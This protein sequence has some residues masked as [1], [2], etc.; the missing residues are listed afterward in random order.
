MTLHTGPQGI[1]GTNGTNG[2]NGAKGDTGPVGPSYF[3]QSGTNI[4]YSGGLVV[5]NEINIQN[6][7][8]TKSMQFA[9]VDNYSLGGGWFPASSSA[10]RIYHSAINAYSYINAYPLVI[11]DFSLTA[12]A[13]AAGNTEQQLY[14]PLPEYIYIDIHLNELTLILPNINSNVGGVDPKTQIFRFQIR[15][16]NQSQG[17]YYHIQTY[18]N[19]SSGGTIYNNNNASQGYY[20]IPGVSLAEVHFYLGNWYINLFTS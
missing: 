19:N 20:V 15:Q 13:D 4:S 8:N 6:S 17:K 9:F 18:G 12:S 3:T 10:L 5:N 2:T 1:A 14:F 7:S 11:K 16:I